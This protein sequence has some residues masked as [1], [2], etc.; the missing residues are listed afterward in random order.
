MTF[1]KMVLDDLKVTSRIGA[2][3][4]VL[5]HPQE[6]WRGVP[7]LPILRHFLLLI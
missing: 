6:E 5:K 3:A 2:P 1:Y 7:Q 4:V